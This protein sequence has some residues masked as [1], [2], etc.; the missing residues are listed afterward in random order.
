MLF[1]LENTDDVAF[2]ASSSASLTA[3][4]TRRRLADE[5]APS[6]GKIT[7]SLAMVVG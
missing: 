5:S 7:R 1:F 6:G 2:Y 3:V 4:S